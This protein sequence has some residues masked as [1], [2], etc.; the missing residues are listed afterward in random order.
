MKRTT[1][2]NQRQWLGKPIIE[3][4][5][6]VVGADR[7]HPTRTLTSTANLAIETPTTSTDDEVFDIIVSEKLHSNLSDVVK[8]NC[9]FPHP[10][11]NC[12][13]AVNSIFSEDEFRF[14][15]G[16]LELLQHVGLVEGDL[17]M[18]EPQIFG[19]LYQPG[20]WEAG[21]ANAPYVIRVGKQKLEL[22]KNLAP[23]R[24]NDQKCHLQFPPH[25]LVG[26]SERRSWRREMLTYHSQFARTP[27]ALATSMTIVPP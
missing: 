9:E 6:T 10:D 26:N 3:T 24:Q 2:A 27:I 4:F 1:H 17:A 22:M 5:T 19:F 25:D 11:A 12:Q 23:G 20:N 14:R 18:A 21:A 15:G 16:S 8:R 7:W 13:L